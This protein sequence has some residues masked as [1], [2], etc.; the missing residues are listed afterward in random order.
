MYYIGDGVIVPT[1]YS[2]GFAG[3]QDLNNIHHGISYEDDLESW[4][5]IYFGYNYELKR[6]YTFVRFFDRVEEFQ[7]DGIIH[8][9]PNRLRFSLGNDRFQKSFNG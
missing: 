5:W 7:F 4:F 2:F 6:A 3:D 8:Q 9:I 1:T